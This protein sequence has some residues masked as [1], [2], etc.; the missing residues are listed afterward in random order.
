[1]RIIAGSKNNKSGFYYKGF[2]MALSSMRKGI[3][4][5]IFL[6]LLVMGAAGLVVMDWTGSYSHG[7][8]RSEVAK[9]E[10][11]HISPRD[12]DM[13][14]QRILRAQKIDPQQA[15]EMGI[16]N[17]ILAGRIMAILMNKTAHD[18]GV[19]VSD[20][21]VATR[22]S[23][24]ITPFT[25]I[26][27][28]K[29]AAL[30]RLLQA[31][32]MS[33]AEFVEVI[34]NEVATTLLRQ[35]F[36]AGVYVPNVMAQSLTRFQ[37]EKRDVEFIQF[38][39]ADASTP[40]APNDAELKAFYD[41]I[42][43][44]FTVPEKRDVTV[45]V[46]D[47][48]KFDAGVSVSDDEIKNFYNDNKDTFT[49]GDKTKPLAEVKD[50]IRKEL[51]AAKIA[52]AQFEVVS[53][54][55]DR[56]AAGESFDKLKSEYKL[57]TITAKDIEKGAVAIPTL[58]KNFAKDEEKIIQSIW[59]LQAG[60]TSSMS[61][62][63][64]GRMFAV[65]IDKTTPQRVRPLDEVKADVAARFIAN[66]KADANITAA[67]VLLKDIKDGKKD[68]A[69]AGT[70]QSTTIARGD[71][72]KGALPALVAGALLMADKGEVVTIPTADS[73]Y[74][75]RV[76]NATLPDAKAPDISKKKDALKDGLARETLES[77]VAYMERTGDV[78]INQAQLERMYGSQPEAQ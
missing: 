29:K 45:A 27:G 32:N 51:M 55:E 61:D 36:T 54:I 56:L 73:V 4:S 19:A 77:L 21:D 2:T 30:Q 13:D 67:Q 12:F 39:H 34:R 20:A 44:D 5:A 48:Q 53:Q 71:A 10:G 57:E 41:T 11:V 40:T 17:Q 66:K 23:Q 74:L 25:G 62:L 15:Y 69:K 18:L 60:E 59:A 47:A 70:V 14:V 35:S 37:G 22:I 75:A 43:N 72:A 78:K 26:D 49:T 6:G 31:Q 52:D 64:D 7:T 16:I 58:S 8:G 65:T 38:K 50:S 68:F 9:V 24:I 1:M 42:K 33:E 28:D 46:F 76:K 63:S 3:F